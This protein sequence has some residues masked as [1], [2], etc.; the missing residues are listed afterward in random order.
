MAYIEAFIYYIAVVVFM[1]IVIFGGI[2]VTYILL[3]QIKIFFAKEYVTLE[4]VKKQV[5]L[6]F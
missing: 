4:I 3:G 2:V 6:Y 1:F 5:F